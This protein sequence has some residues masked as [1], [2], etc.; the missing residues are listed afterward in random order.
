MIKPKIGK[1]YRVT[2]LKRFGGFVSGALYTVSY[3]DEY[4]V[5][6]RGYNLMFD[7]NVLQL[8]PADKLPPNARINS[9][10][11]E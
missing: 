10:K 11:V 7:I 1:Q 8:E 2:F 4:I 6:F 5:Q 3:C 9:I